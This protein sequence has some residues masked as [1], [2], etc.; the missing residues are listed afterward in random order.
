MAQPVAILYCT[1]LI[2]NTLYFAFIDVPR[3]ADN[4]EMRKLQPKSLGE[5]TASARKSVK[6]ALSNFD[7][8]RNIVQK[9]VES[10]H[11]GR[12]ICCLV[13]GFFLT[14]EVLLLI[15]S[16]NF[17]GFTTNLAFKEKPEYIP[18][19]LYQ[20]MMVKFGKSVHE[21]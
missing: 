2:L 4:L 17:Q 6:L 16:I 14:G 20:P 11:V 18:W 13:T 1:A 19:F 3:I 15:T 21:A 8:T 9:C 12:F 7:W 10:F 5:L